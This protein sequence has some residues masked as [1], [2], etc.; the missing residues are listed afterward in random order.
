MT[1]ASPGK[2]E[3]LRADVVFVGAGPA[4]L[5]GALHLARRVREYNEGS[6]PTPVAGMER[7][8]LEAEIVVLEKARQVGQHNLSGAVL[9]PSVL[10]ELV[11]DFE[12][13][14]FPGGM[15]I[16]DDRFVFLSRRAALQVPSFLIPPAN[17]NRGFWTVSLQRL[18]AWL[19][20][21]CEEAGVQIFPDTTAV[22]LEMKGRAVSGV[23]TGDKGLGRDGAPKSNYQP[24]IVL[25]AQVTVLGEGPRGTLAED[26]IHA[27]EL[28]RDCN[29]QIYSLGVKEIVRVP[30]AR[31]RAGTVVHT[32]G[33]PLADSAFGGGFLY[34]MEPD[35]FSVGLVASLA[36]GDPNFDA[37]T[38]LQLL[39]AHPYV[40][41][42]L[43]GGEVLSYGAK[44]IPE[45]GHWSLPRPYAAGALL[46][47]DSAGFVNIRQ[48]KGIHY[49]M[50]SGMLAAETAFEALVAGD[51]SEERLSGYARRLADSVVH[52]DLYRDRNFRHAFHGGFRAGLIKSQVNAFLGGGPRRRPRLEPDHASLRP[53]PPRAQT[54]PKLPSDSNL[55]IDKL[56]AVYKS[57]TVHREDQP[58]HIHIVDPGRCTDTCIPRFGTAPCTHFCPAN[59]YELVGERSEQHIQVNFANCVHCKTCVILDPIDALETDNLQNIDWRAPAEGGPKYNLL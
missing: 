45:G 32:M 59:V 41:E 12:T 30:E 46:I 8:P 6:I 4:S 1:N 9:N 47:G 23:L 44:T 52:R 14:Q 17:H 35:L 26:L 43:R 15:R 56:T 5:A 54:K 36:W 57:G 3:R 21:L 40:H 34:S 7:R 42:F 49:A 53:S 38:H 16:E 20:A 50:K 27:L 10:R 29:P 58:S 55:F 51:A 28:N 11:P 24:G 18:T 48:L 31:A 22:G 13:R 33:Y 37:Q 25:E 39:K 2:R 19:A